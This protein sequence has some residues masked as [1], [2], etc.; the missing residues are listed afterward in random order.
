MQTRSLAVTIA[1]VLLVPAITNADVSIVDNK[2]VV[3]GKAHVSATAYDDG[4]EDG[5]EISSNSSRLGFKGE[6]GLDNNMKALWQYE[7]SIDVSGEE[8]TFGGRNRFLGLEGG[9]GTVLLGYHDTPMKTAASKLTY[10]GDTVADRR[11]I[12]GQTSA[13]GNEFN[14]R[15]S[16][17]I[18]Y[19]TPSMNG[20]QL[21]A[22]YSADNED[23][24]SNDR[25][26]DLSSVGITYQG[27]NLTFM[28]AYEDQSLS[29]GTA[30]QDGYRI[31]GSYRFGDMEIKAIY[32][33]LDGD[34]AVVNR[35]AYGVGAAYKAG[36]NKFMLQYMVADESDV[37][38]DGADL[39]A[40]GISHKLGKATEIYG[41][42]AELSNDPSA[43]YRLGRSGFGEPIK[44]SAAGEDVTGFSIGLVHKF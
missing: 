23:N 30:S 29:G 8:G 26:D 13:G 41:M 33:S 37:D 38:N 12:L 20:I 6:Y 2:L 9:F 11:S 7:S 31:G 32:E 1:A 43:S 28:A 42:Y 5:V 40:V 3:Y 10:F 27:E 18:M 14:V 25:D 34:S 24:A 36:K 17:M 19:S 15:A 16:S 4:A 39:I 22:L 35:D 21:T 44:P